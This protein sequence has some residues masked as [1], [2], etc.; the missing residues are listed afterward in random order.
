MVLSSSCEALMTTMVSSQHLR[1]T[2]ST[3]AIPIPSTRSRVR[4]KGTVSGVGRVLPCSNATPA[5]LKRYRESCLSYEQGHICCYWLTRYI[6]I[7]RIV[8]AGDCLVVVPQWSD[9]RQLKPGTPGSN[10][11]WLP[12]FSTFQKQ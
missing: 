6:Y 10:S 4:R 12:A 8:K 7:E 9:Y 5:K 3:P 2:P 11:S 1:N